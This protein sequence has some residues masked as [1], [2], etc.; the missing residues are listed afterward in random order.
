MIIILRT[1][2]VT[3]AS[4]QLHD[5][6]LVMKNTSLNMNLFKYKERRTPERLNTVEMPRLS[7][8]HPYGFTP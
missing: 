5:S 1:S 3:P 8:W 6:L 7:G 4:N 2:K